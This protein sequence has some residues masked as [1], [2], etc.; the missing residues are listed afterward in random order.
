VGG[1]VVEKEG[2]IHISNVMLIDPKDKK[3]TRVGVAREGGAR[4]RIARRSGAKFD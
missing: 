3:P 4:N 1:G 2:P